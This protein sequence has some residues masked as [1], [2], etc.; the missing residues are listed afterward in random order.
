M[1]D[2]RDFLAASDFLTAWGVYLL[3]ALVLL[4]LLWRVSRRWQRDLRALAMGLSA[5]LLLTPSAVPG[6]GVLA[7]ALSFL[8]LGGLSPNS[9][10]IL[11]P[12]IV[13]LAILTTLMVLLVIAY[14]VLRR[15]HSGRSA[16]RRGHA[17]DQRS[18]G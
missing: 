6:H 4:G 2:S 15:Q 12:V 13:K 8:A 17:Q 11:A 9:S 18:R 1:F 7:P 16:Q 3:A 14:A 5:V 10:E